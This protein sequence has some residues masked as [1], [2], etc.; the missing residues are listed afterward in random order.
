MA[1]PLLLPLLG[2]LPSLFS[3]GAEIVSAVTG[4]E[5]PA[6]ALASPEAMAAH[7]EGLP[8]DQQAEIQKRILDHVEA[9]DRNSTERWRD[10]MAMETNAEVD[11]LRATAR[12]QI[13]LQAMGVIRI[14]AFIL[15]WAMIA[16]S[17]EW[18][19]RAGF[20]IWGC[21]TSIGPDG[22]AVEVCRTMPAELSVAWMLAQLEP[23]TT[24]IWPPLLA[25]FAAC[26]SVIKA[27][28]GA[29][30]RDK[31]RADEMAHGKPLSA[32]AATIEAAGGGLAAIVKAFR[33]R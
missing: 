10:R 33:G 9:L 19:A 17:V 1:F 12:P 7:I 16:L 3:A 18:L 25:S 13:A 23:V 26:V 32:T 30:E 11:K 31:A 8:A 28:M 29:R 20:A 27:Y 15:V 21:S 2:A 4:E 6:S 24:I 22:L 14:F 5:A